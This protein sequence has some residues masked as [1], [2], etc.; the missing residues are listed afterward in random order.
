MEKRRQKTLMMDQDIDRQ[1]K[2][3]MK[4]LVLNYS[5]AVNMMLA[6]GYKSIVVNFNLKE[7]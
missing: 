2:Q 3:I 4:E 7:D 1:I 6:V 5:S